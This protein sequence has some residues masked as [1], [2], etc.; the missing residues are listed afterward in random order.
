MGFFFWLAPASP[1]GLRV[2]SLG[3]LPSN[4]RIGTSRFARGVGSL[5]GLPFPANVIHRNSDENWL[6]F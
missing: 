4:P 3:Q 2:G 5:T 6:P 1:I